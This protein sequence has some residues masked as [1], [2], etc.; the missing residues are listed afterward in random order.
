LIVVDTS[1]VVAYLSARDAGHEAVVA[2]WGEVDEAPV[3][4]P[5][6]VAEMDYLLARNP[7][8]TQALRADLRDGVYGVHW[9]HDALRETLAVAERRPDI[10]LTDASLV[11]LAARVGT[12]RIATLDERHFRSLAPIT[13]EERFTLL[14][15]DADAH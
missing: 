5:L 9:W 2:W 15:A 13:G 3:T 6:A 10:G 12:T 4:T 11:A 7:A 1:V 8:A 14:P